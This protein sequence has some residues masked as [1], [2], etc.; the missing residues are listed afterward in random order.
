MKLL[1]VIIPLCMTMGFIVSQT[2]Q[3]DSAQEIVEAYNRTWNEAFN[4]GDVIGLSKLY[5]E[6]A[7]VV[8]PADKSRADPNAIRGFWADQIRSGL[9]NYNIITVD[10]TA[11][12]DTIYQSALWTA[13][14]RG[15]DGQMRYFG[16]YL[17]NVFEHQAN[18]G[19]KSRLHTWH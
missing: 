17:V 12:G 13:R 14:R 2:A 16:G 7:V 5:T 6:D 9:S 11:K 15:I 10:V 3:A 19:W 8:P 1:R 18:G 4:R